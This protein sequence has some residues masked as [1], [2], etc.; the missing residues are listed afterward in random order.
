MN[1]TVS[2]GIFGSG[3]RAGTRAVEDGWSAAGITCYTDYF[4]DNK[5]WIKSTGKE[6]SREAAMN[7]V[8]NKLGK[9]INIANYIPE[10]IEPDYH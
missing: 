3:W 4:G 7:Y 1:K 8:A 10:P 5:Y 2:I 9:N 6:I